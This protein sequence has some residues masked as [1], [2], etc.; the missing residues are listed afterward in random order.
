MRSSAKTR[1]LVSMVVGIGLAMVLVV[2]LAACGGDDDAGDTEAAV[3]ETEP[4]PEET[5]PASEGEEAAAGDGAIPTA[6]LYHGRTDDQTWNTSMSDPVNRLEEEGVIEVVSSAESVD[7]GD[8]PRAMREAIE[9]AGAQMVIAHASALDRATSEVSSEF[10]DVCFL[11]AYGTEEEIPPNVTYYFDNATEPN[12]LAGMAAADVS[13]SG[14]I[15]SVG[16]VDLD[17][18]VDGVDAFEN[19]ARAINP[20]IEHL[21]TW[22][23]DFEDPLRGKEAGEAQIRQGADVLFALGDGTGLGTVEAAVENDVG[24]IGAWFDQVELAPDNVITGFVTDWAHVVRDT[25]EK[26]KAEGPGNCGLG[27]YVATLENEGMQ[28][29]PFHTYEDQISDET[30]QAIE[31]A[32]QEIIDGTLDPVTG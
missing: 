12:Y 18:I 20:D 21:V 8:G 3:E 28:L 31:Q 7:P 32:R 14:V 25:A 10:P 2:G 30:K 15:G 13:E 29:A 24:V 23:G 16:G 5:E 22:V 4:A 17:P 27:A 6:V 26:A 1:R 19:G 11:Q 9:Q